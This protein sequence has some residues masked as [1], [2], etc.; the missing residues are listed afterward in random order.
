MSRRTILVSLTLVAAAGASHAAGTLP[1]VLD[2]KHRALFDERGAWQLDADGGTLL[3]HCGLRVWTKDGFH[4]QSEARPVAAPF[5]GPAGRSFHGRIRAGTRTLEYW[6]TATPVANGLMVSY[7]VDASALADGEEVA[8]CF[9]LPLA[10]YAKATCTVGGEAPVVLPGQKAPQPRLVERDAASVA[11]QR[12]GVAFSCVRRP[13][14]KIIVQDARHW[15]NPWFE[16]QLYA[17]RMPG[18]PPGWRSVAFLI[19]FGPVPDGPVLAAVV[20]SAERVGCRELFEL[21]CRFWAPYDNPFDPEQVSLS[22]EVTSPSGARTTV[23]GFYSRDYA[24]SARGTEGDIQPRG[25][26]RWVLRVAP[27]EAGAYT[28]VATVASGAKSRSW[29]AVRFVAL[30]AAG[31]RFVVAPKKQQRYLEHPDGEPVLLIGHN[32]CWPP[33]GGGLKAAEAAF[34]RMARSGINATRLWLCSWGL[35]LEGDHPDDY[36]LADAWRLDRLLRAAREDGLYVQLCLDNFQDLAAKANAAHNP[37]LAANGGPCQRPEQF[38]SDERARQQY[39]R[40]LRYLAAR[41]AA[42][43]SLLSWELFT[44]VA[45]A[46]ARPRDPAV[47]AWARESAARIKQLDPYAHPVTISVGLRSGWDELWRLDGIDMIQ[48]HTYI[49]RPTDQAGP[50]DLDSAALVLRERDAF[51]AIAKPVW[52]TEFGFMGTRAFNPLNEADTTGGHLHDSLWAAALGGCAGTPLHWWWDSYVAERDLY[53]HYR[54]LANF[55]RRTP[56]PGKG[57]TPVRSKPGADVLVVGFRGPASALLWMRRA[58][59]TWFR[60]VVERRPPVPLGLAVVELGGLAAGR[61]RVQW[62]DTY[63]G[64][65]ITHTELGTAG[66]RLTLRAPRQLPDVAC[67]IVRVGD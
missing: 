31:Q 42:F 50:A 4:T 6:Q 28:L 32:Y 10:T 55:F 24:P 47:L 25:C 11:V 8:A 57:W 51:K 19:S 64:Q 46:T 52:I 22:A 12:D 44:E 14:G 43:T 34:R 15:D 53:Y 33:R 62:W 60:R 39:R 1:V 5:E 21:D 16:V 45:A 48:P 40:R 36:R 26:G 18:D 59:S 27:T 2:A 7:A 67:K 37:Y 66:G 29:Q 58:E 49:R 63:N 41:Y 65:P 9:D 30:P 3:A 35:R 54:A 38:F 17:R 23:P 13:T 20:P 56:L 61:Y